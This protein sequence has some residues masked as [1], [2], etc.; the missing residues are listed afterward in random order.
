[1]EFEIYVKENGVYNKIL[2]TPPANSNWNYLKN[3]KLLLDSQIEIIRDDISKIFNNDENVNLKRPR[4]D[5]ENRQSKIDQLTSFRKANIKCKD[6]LSGLLSL[7]E[8]II[9]ENCSNK[10]YRTPVGV[11]YE[12]VGT[13]FLLKDVGL[14]EVIKYVYMCESCVCAVDEDV[15]MTIQNNLKTRRDLLE[16]GERLVPNALG[17]WHY[18]E[19]SKYKP[20]NNAVED[21]FEPRRRKF[22]FIEIKG[23]KNPFIKITEE[24]AN[25]GKVVTIK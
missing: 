20:S 15:Y 10:M 9:C 25:S 18:T 6:E 8:F 17:Y 4:V 16:Q 1:M 23:Q 21:E 3:L 12:R 5:D 19:N 22:E 7:E 11:S 14:H 24:Y 2:V 13:K